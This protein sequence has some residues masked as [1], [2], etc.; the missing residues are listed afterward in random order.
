MN[1]QIKSKLK[2]SFNMIIN[3][4]HVEIQELL[5]TSL[6]YLNN[7]QDSFISNE[8]SSM[9]KSLHPDLIHFQTA[10]NFPCWS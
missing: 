8:K 5:D 6:N 9:N 1:D 4:S 2:N 7:F 3:Y 10:A